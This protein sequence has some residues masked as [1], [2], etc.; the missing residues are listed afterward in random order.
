MLREQDI[1]GVLSLLRKEWPEVTEREVA[2]A[3]LCDTYLDKGVA[4]RAIYGTTNDGVEAFYESAKMRK[5][6]EALRPFGI[7]GVSD[8]SISKEQ[9]K[10]ALIHMIDVIN[11]GMSDGSIEVDKGLKM[12]ADIRFKLNDKFEMEETSK[13]RRIIVVPQKHD[14]ICPHTRKECTQMPSIEACKTYYGLVEG[15]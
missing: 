5:L 9:N 13:G 4:C 2:F 11:R 15:G 6:R 1:E 10:A 3:V 7:G 8:A 14:V 12:V